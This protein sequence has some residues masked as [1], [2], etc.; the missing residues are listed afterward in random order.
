[1]PILL[2]K[3]AHSLICLV[4]LLLMPF[5]IPRLHKW[6]MSLPEPIAQIFSLAQTVEKNNS[7]NIAGTVSTTPGEIEVFGEIAPTFLDFAQQD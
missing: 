2:N 3:T 6:Q 1:M 5:V 4:F 7:P